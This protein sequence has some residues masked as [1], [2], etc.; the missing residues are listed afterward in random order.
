METVFLTKG[1]EDDLLLNYDEAISGEEGSK[2]KQAMD[3]EM[4]NVKVM[5]TWI[6]KEL[7]KERTVLD[8]DGYF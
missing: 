6:R 5:G 7:P 2:W 3:E 8:A 4:E 1:T